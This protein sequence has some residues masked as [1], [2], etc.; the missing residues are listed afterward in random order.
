MHLK[1]K[2]GSFVK[3]NCI[4]KWEGRRSIVDMASAAFG[5][6]ERKMKCLQD[7]QKNRMPTSETTNKENCRIQ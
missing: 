4:L 2:L 6:M 5:E 3:T 7:R 1:N